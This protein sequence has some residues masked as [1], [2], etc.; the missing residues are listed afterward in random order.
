MLDVKTYFKRHF[1]CRYIYKKEVN[2]IMGRKQILQRNYDEEGNLISKECSCC[3][4]IKLPSEFSK[5]ER[6]KDGLRSECK[7]CS[8]KRHQEYYQDNK[9]KIKEKSK[10][11]SQENKDRIKEKKRKYYQ[12]NIEKKI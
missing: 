4:K 7:E 2:L 8:K 12:E 3:H 6:S 11:Y 10:K 9:D 1:K 5:R